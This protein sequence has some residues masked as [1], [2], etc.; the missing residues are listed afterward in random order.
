MPHPSADLSGRDS[1]L[2]LGCAM[3]DHTTTSLA[4]EMAMLVTGFSREKSATIGK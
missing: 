4:P 2:Y 1:T 3:V